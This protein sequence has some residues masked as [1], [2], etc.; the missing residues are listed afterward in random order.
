MCAVKTQDNHSGVI[1]SES[2]HRVEV[3][4]HRKTVHGYESGA[5]VVPSG[6]AEPNRLRS[7]QSRR[8]NAEAP[9]TWL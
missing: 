1:K 3:S 7:G 8:G 6:S 2:P 4:E 5:K 9:I